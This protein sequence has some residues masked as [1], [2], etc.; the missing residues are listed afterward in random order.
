M[1]LNS[2]LNTGV[3][4][5]NAGQTG[6]Q[7][8]STNLSN[9]STEGYTRRNASV[10]PGAVADTGSP[11]RSVDAFVDRRLLTARS[12]SGEASAQSLALGTL[13]A[14]FAEGDG[15]LGSSIDRFQASLQE[16]GSRP[17]DMAVR[18]QVLARAGNVANAFQNA[19]AG[20]DQARADSNARI[21]GAVDEVNQRLRQIS[22]LTGQISKAEI[23]GQEASD[24][25]D[26]RDVLVREVAERVPVTVVEQDQGSQFSLLLAGS[27]TLVSPDGKVSELKAESGSG[28]V[29]ITKVAAGQSVDVTSMI[30]S[31]S[32]GGQI[33]ARDGSLKDLEQKLDQM[34]YDFQQQYNQV[35]AQGVAL[36]GQSGYNLFEPA[37]SVDGAAA[38][39]TIS[40]DV[41]GRPDL[42]A[43]AQDAAALPSDNRGALAL[44]NL[45]SV[46][47]ALGGM[48][49]T[50][51][52][53]SLT[54]A[55]GMAVQ[56]AAQS[57]SFASGA[58][59]QVSALRDNMSGVNS[60]EEMVSL[61]RYQRAY[62]AS[63]QVIQ[64]ADQMMGE[65][66]NLRR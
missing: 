33:K 49:V 66:M 23:S 3:T 8:A 36:D 30:S 26:R 31:G 65:L 19:A 52:L 57:E 10:Q 46:G 42:L 44:S 37:T 58:L 60:D 56:S 11:R 28:D 1:S 48:T 32:I 16:L 15:G 63:L 59:E 20:L 51:A 29:R 61:M 22:A 55:A 25:R 62:E 9:V 43:A 21:T 17:N 24:L 12:A 35:H 18:E 4:G 50:E 13:D 47:F 2:I 34:A 41:A 45:S 54:G 6:V 5:M 40:A 64:V 27:Q 53:A 39:M 38:A 14:V 7:I